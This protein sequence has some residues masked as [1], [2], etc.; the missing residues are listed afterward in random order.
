M[1]ITPSGIKNPDGVYFLNLLIIDK[2][3]FLSD[4]LEI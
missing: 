1:V 4:H 3:K 2:I